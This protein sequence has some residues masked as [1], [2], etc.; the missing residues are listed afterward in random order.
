M[1][2]EAWQNGPRSRGAT[3]AECL[4][5]IAIL[6]VMISL[7]AG[8]VLSARREARV[9]EAEACLKQVSVALEAFYLDH[10]QLP[11][12]GTDLRKALEPYIKDSSVFDNP[13][14]SGRPLGETLSLLYRQPNSQAFDR[15]HHYLTA[16]ASRDGKHAVIL[17]TG[18]QVVR[19]SG[20][21]FDLAA[22]PAVAMATLI[23][24]ATADDQGLVPIIYTVDPDIPDDGGGAGYETDDEIGEDPATDTFQIALIGQPNHP[25]YTGIDDPA[26]YLEW[27]LCNTRLRILLKAGGD[28]FVLPS[29]CENLKMLSEDSGINGLEQITT[30]RPDGTQQTIREWP[31]IDTDL[32]FAWERERELREDPAWEWSQW[33][34][35]HGDPGWRVRAVIED[36]NVT[37]LQIA[38]AISLNVDVRVT[39]ADKT[40]E[41]T[42]LTIAC[43][44][45]MTIDAVKGP[46]TVWR[47]RQP[48]IRR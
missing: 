6:A 18:G 26:T 20:L 41:M 23:T 27:L 31:L 45:A 22:G 36:G 38:A 42:H 2:R 25:D 47:D 48:T 1:K 32:W 21:H 15:P 29:E 46:A 33:A 9:C 34:A 11:S 28:V 35:A 8:V 3:L 4:T 16:L 14:W 17:L 19:R 44:G 7:V 5:V 30:Q 37:S 39:A 13:L 40:E 10:Q 24:A 43:S 12:Q